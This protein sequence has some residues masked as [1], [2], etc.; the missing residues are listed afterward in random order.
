MRR[1][2]DVPAAARNLRYRAPTKGKTKRT[3]K[4]GCTTKTYVGSRHEVSAAARNLRYGALQREK[5]KGQPGMAVPLKPTWDHGTK[6]G[7]PTR[8]KRKRT[9]K[10]GCPTKTYGSRRTPNAWNK[11]AGGAYYLAGGGPCIATD[12]GSSSPWGGNTAQIVGRRYCQPDQ[13][14]NHRRR[15]K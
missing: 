1:G 11:L 10:N 2:D 12:A 15:C 3:A 7:A 6:Y 14:H 5:R 8:G 9:A 4:N 13:P